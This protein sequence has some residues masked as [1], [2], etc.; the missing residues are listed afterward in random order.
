M[1]YGHLFFWPFGTPCITNSILPVR[2]SPVMNH[3]STGQEYRRIPF[4][5]FTFPKSTCILVDVAIVVCFA[6]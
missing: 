3:P 5:P 6:L 4:I 2:F 1:L